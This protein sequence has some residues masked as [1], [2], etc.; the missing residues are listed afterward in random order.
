MGGNKRG[1][2]H[3]TDHNDIFSSGKSA[4]EAAVESGYTGTEEQFN[5]DM[6]L[7]GDTRVQAIESTQ[8][9]TENGY[10]IEGVVSEWDEQKEN[11]EEVET[12][13]TDI[14][15]GKITLSTDSK[16]KRAGQNEEENFITAFTNIESGMAEFVTKDDLGQES[17]TVIHGGKITTG[18]LSGEKV[19]WNLDDGT[20]LIGENVANHK[21]YWDGETLSI[22]GELHF[23]SGVSLED[24]V[25]NLHGQIEDAENA[26]KGYADTQ[27]INFATAVD[28][29]ISDLQTQI[30]GKITTW[31]Y[32]AVPTTAN[33]PASTWT[34][35][36]IKDAHLGDLYYNTS[37]GRAYRWKK[38]STTYSWEPITD[39]RITTALANASTAKDVADSK[40]RVFG[41]TPTPP[42][43]VNDLWVQGT[44]GDIMRCIT[45]STTTYSSAHWVKASKYT[46]DT[47]ANA[48]RVALTTISNEVIQMTSSIN[49]LDT[50]VTTIQ[51]GQAAFVKISDIDGTK[52]TTIID[53]GIIKTGTITANKIAANSITANKFANIA[54]FTFSNSTMLASNSG[55]YVRISGASGYA[56]IRVGPSSSDIRFLVDTDGSMTA[57]NADISGKITAT[58]GKIGALE[59][60]PGLLQYRPNSSN[61]V[62]RTYFSGVT[63]DTYVFASYDSSGTRTFSIARTGGLYATGA[64]ISG[65]IT[66][67]SGTIGGWDIGSYLSSSGTYNSPNYISL[68]PSSDASYRIF[69]TN[70]S[71]TRAFSVD[72]SGGLYA[73]SV[74]VTG[75]ITANSNSSLAGALNSTSGRH[76][77][78]V[79]SS[80]G[81]LGGVGYVSSSGYLKFNGTV[82]VRDDFRVMGDLRVDGDIIYYG[83]MRPQSSDA[84]LKENIT[85]LDIDLARD[86]YNLSMVEFDFI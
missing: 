2:F 49:S 79:Y 61:N 38:V 10:R 60:T 48:N 31:F 3:L 59:I 76:N 15:A 39:T 81:S 37:T 65:K 8:W 71:G 74:T 70:S 27:L 30:D 66:A 21:L 34:T 46:D 20:L 18:S 57:T 75:K 13:V 12:R 5:E 24:E 63:S 51:A 78:S 32:A 53:G 47:T 83:N 29:D 36:A 80:S 56:P 28:G 17:S 45:A 64:D 69:V 14:E 52:S 40:R 72:P 33:V 9:I 54:G 42:Y 50:A 7:I 25:D 84:R 41:S 58:S 73:T 67:T 55:S 43:D 23:S 44:S 62:N 16:I 22:K 1:V 86:F 11:F 4:Y 85:A 77:G 26:A 35:T 6:K 68:N 19:K 82:N